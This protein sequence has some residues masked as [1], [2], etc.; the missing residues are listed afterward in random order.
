MMFKQMFVLKLPFLQNC[1]TRICCVRTGNLHIT[2]MKKMFL[3]ECSTVPCCH[4]ATTNISAT[5]PTPLSP[6]PALESASLTHLSAGR[7]QPVQG[8]E[9]SATEGVHITTALVQD[10]CLESAPP[11]PTEKNLGPHVHNLLSRLKR[12]NA[13][14][15]VRTSPLRLGLLRASIASLTSLTPPASSKVEQ[16]VGIVEDPYWRSG[17]SVPHLTSVQLP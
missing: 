17:G 15:N 1:V 12:M 16:T 11:P 6:M 14:D 3:T 8:G 9:G 2:L 7:V 5:P 4:H 10:V 13:V